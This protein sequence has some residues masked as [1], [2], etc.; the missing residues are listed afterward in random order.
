MAT[1]NAPAARDLPSAAWTGSFML[2][3]GGLAASYLNTGG[4]YSFSD[5]DGDGWSDSV[6]CA[7]TDPTAFALPD[8]TDLM[9]STNTTTFTWASSGGSGARYDVLR[10]AVGELPVG[11]KPSEVCAASGISAATLSDP[12][13]PTS[14]K[15]LW[16]L[17]RGRNACGVGTYGTRSDGTVINSTVCP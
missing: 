8:I 12:T 3:W 4:R 11:N 9:I 7:P 16:W 10:G 13:V 14:G 17:V 2:V 1:V 5:M 15:I 6:D